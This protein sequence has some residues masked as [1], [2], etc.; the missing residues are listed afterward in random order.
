MVQLGVLLQLF[1]LLLTTWGESGEPAHEHCVRL[2]TSM[3]T[4]FSFASCVTGPE[5]S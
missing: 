3:A 1:Q 5:C 4:D 2:V